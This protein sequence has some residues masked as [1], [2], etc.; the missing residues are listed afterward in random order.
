MVETI[1]IDSKW[2]G[3]I[4]LD[5]EILNYLKKKKIKSLALFASVQFLELDDVIKQLKDLDIKIEINTFIM[6]SFD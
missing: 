3:E 4:K 5:K 6:K 2:V 1:F